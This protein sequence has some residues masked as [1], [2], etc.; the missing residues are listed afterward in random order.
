MFYGLVVMMYR[1]DHGSPHFHVRYAEYRAKYTISP[2]ARVRGKLPRRAAS[3]VLEWA[4][5][6]QQELMENWELARSG[7][8]ARKI[9]PLD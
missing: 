6:H 4:A 9:P 2:I 1:D 7:E 5:L 8:P 3:L